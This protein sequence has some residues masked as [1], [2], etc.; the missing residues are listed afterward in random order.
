MLWR[1]FSEGGSTIEYSIPR[2]VEEHADTL[3]TRFLGWVHDLG[4]AQI[5]GRR[6]VDCLALRPGLSYWWLFVG[7]AKTHYSKLP[8]V[9]DS[10][11][12]LALEDLIAAHS[13]NTIILASGDKTLA[14]AFRLWCRNARLAFEW[15]RLN[16]K[17]EPVSRVRRLYRS[18]PHPVQ[19][20]VSLLRYL[21]QRWPL[22][23]VGAAQFANS[24]AKITVCSYFDNLDMEA[25]SQAR[26]YSRYWT[27]LPD[28][29]AQ[30]GSRTNWLQ[31]YIQD[32][33]VPTAQQARDLLTR[34][35]QN[36]AGIQSHTTLDGVLGWPVIRGV[37]RDYGSILLAGLRLRKARRHFSPVDSRVDLWPLFEQDWRSSMFGTTAMSNCLV[38]NLLE[39]TLK[40]LP[41]QELGVYLLENLGWEMAF[42]H[43]WKA[44][45][46]G[47]LVGVPHSTVRYWDLRYFFDPRSY[48][49][50]GKNDLPL[51]DVVA[52]NGPAALATYRQ[53]GFP[54]DRIVEVE[55]LR[56]LDLAD[57]LHVQNVVKEP[58]MS[59]LRALVLGDYLPSA[60]HRQMQWLVEAAPSLP[61]ST[62]YI[63]KPHPNCPVKASDYPALQMQITGSPLAGLLDDCDVAYTSNLTS[64]AVDA[65][66]TGVPVVSVLDGKAL[67]M[68]PLRGLLAG[69]RFVTSP[70]ELVE[71]LSSKSELDSGF[72]RKEYFTV[73]PALPRWKALLSQVTH[74]Q[75]LY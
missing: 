67:N 69:V 40:Y 19:A 52:I 35:N 71:A 4:E 20:V 37:L 1:G 22:R 29:L 53:G 63:V 66:S 7:V 10:L 39:H 25:A 21:R 33:S 65:Y 28:A 58:S 68:S 70:Q 43:S 44:A 75:A 8:Y 38:L 47:R 15:R 57:L 5:D 59:P 18:L 72:K 26:F 36:G 13:D 3:R 50:T 14:R 23:Q 34:F 41:R 27:A 16:E 54:E 45:G 6:L 24:A 32:E 12:L 60:T 48:Q 2:R 62:R 49:R 73:D 55:A 30:D 9:Y 42:I 51:P 61:A 64:A 46:H 74:E 17:G 11:R 31:L 56:Y